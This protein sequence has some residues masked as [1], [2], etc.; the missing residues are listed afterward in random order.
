M[1]SVIRRMEA[2]LGLASIANV[3]K[4]VDAMIDFGFADRCTCNAAS[5]SAA[6]STSFRPDAH[7]ID[8]TCSGWIAKTTAPRQDAK[9]DLRSV[10][11]IENTS[12]DAT[13]CAS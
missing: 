13:Q 8:S 9:S 5:A 3:N 1:M 12:T 2:A 7:A 6:A 10:R 11:K 4:I